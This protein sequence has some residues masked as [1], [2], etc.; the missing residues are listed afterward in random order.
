MKVC[1]K[2]NSKIRL[3][4]VVKSIY[5]KNGLIE[6]D[7]CKSK[8]R[9]KNYKI[10]TTIVILSMV[11]VL[12]YLNIWC[13]TT[14]INIFISTLIICIITILVFIVLLFIVPWEEYRE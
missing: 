4:S 10:I 5:N 8:F 14:Y 2:C 1:C 13:E 11:A 3:L 9:I 6:C 7:N 12:S